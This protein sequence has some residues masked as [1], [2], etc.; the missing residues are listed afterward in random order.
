MKNILLQS[1]LL[2]FFQIPGFSINSYQS[3]DTLFVWAYHGLNLRESPAAS[4]TRRTTIPYGSSLVVLDSVRVKTFS[5]KEYH[6]QFQIKGY[7]S[8]V[9]FDTLEGWVF[10]GYLSRHPALR[11]FQRPKGRSPEPE[12]Y[13][14][15]GKRAWG[16]RSFQQLDLKQDKPPTDTSSRRDIYHFK[17]GAVYEIRRGRGNGGWI[18]ESFRFP[19]LSH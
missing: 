1:L 12:E 7:W 18:S 11:H 19:D 14:A 4:G 17:N 9:R 13:M 2:A 6:N 16:L 15:Y 10:D 8:K 3:G 5:T